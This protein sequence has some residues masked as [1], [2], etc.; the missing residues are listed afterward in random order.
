MRLRLRLETTVGAHPVWDSTPA[1]APRTGQWGPANRTQSWHKLG[2]QGTLRSWPPALEGPILALVQ[3]CT[4]LQ[5]EESMGQGT[6]ATGN[7]TIRQAP[8]TWNSFPKQHEV[9][10]MLGLDLGRYDGMFPPEG[11]ETSVWPDDAM[12][13]PQDQKGTQRLFSSFMLSSTVSSQG[14]L[15][16]LS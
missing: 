4:S 15:L 13:Q 8:S 9:P 1:S 3:P 12:S 7:Q 16:A 10:Q 14:G 2:Q 6:M 5:S 11:R